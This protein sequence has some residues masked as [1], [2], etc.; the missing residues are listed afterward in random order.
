MRI[1]QTLHVPLHPCQLRPLDRALA[2]QRRE[3]R[4]R[5][6]QQVRH[7][8]GA[9]LV[10]R[11]KGGVGGGGLAVPRADLLADVAAEGVAGEGKGGREEAAM[12]DR[13]VA[14][15]GLRRDRAVRKDR[16]PDAPKS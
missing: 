11:D 16:L 10:A 1:S 13:R 14:D 2:E 3:V 15:A 8:L 6:P 4:L 7:R 5:E 12:F 9:V